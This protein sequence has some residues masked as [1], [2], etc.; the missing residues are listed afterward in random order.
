MVS[1]HLFDLGAIAP[2]KKT[3]GGSRTGATK[4]NFPALKGMS[5]YKLVIEVNGIREPHWHANADELGYCLQGSAVI[6]LYANGNKNETFLVQEGEAF[7]IPSGSLHAIANVGDVPAEFVLQFSHEEPEDFA[8]STTFNMFSDNVLG[9][10]WDVKADIF[11]DVARHKT[12]VFAAVSSKKNEIPEKARYHSPYHFNLQ[13]SSPQIHV[14]GG[15]AKVAR[16]D[17]WPILKHQAL[18]ALHLDGEGM[19]EPH[20][21]PETAELGYVVE[22]KGKMSIL[23]PSG[24]VDTYEMKAGDIYFIPKAYP[25]H[26]ENLTDGD[27]NICIFFDRIQPE[28]IGFTASVKS[29]SD[30]ILQNSVNLTPEILSHLPTYYENLLIVNKVNP[31]DK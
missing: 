2:Q 21:H 18:Y 17:R 30:N 25:H 27:L 10:T 8:L 12:E 23:S 24:S 4:S 22:G 11:K 3:A 9:N 1:E 28:D 15:T 19:R 31:L 6:Y 13:N 26:I 5:I 29:N 7:L 16:S 20:W 14:H